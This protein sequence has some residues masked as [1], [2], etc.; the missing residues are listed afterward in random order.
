MS[1]P[2]SAWRALLWKDFQQVKSALLLMSFGILAFQLL[3]LFAWKLSP[4]T[5]FENP[6]YVQFAYC[7]VAPVLSIMACVGLLIGQERQ[8]GGWAWSSSLPQSWRQALASKACVAF[9]ASL[10]TLIPVA[11]SPVLLW[12]WRNPNHPLDSS[13]LT[14]IPAFVL[15]MMFELSVFLT[16]AV[17]IFRDSLTGLIVGGFWTAISQVTVSTVLFWKQSG[18]Q[19]D[20]TTWNYQE[21]GLFIF[22]EGI[23]L[24]LGTAAL[25][26]LFRWRWSYGQ[27]TDISLRRRRAIS[28]LLIYPQASRALS[29]RAAPR[30][31]FLMLVVHSLRSS[32]YLRLTIILSVIVCCWLCIR[33]RNFAARELIS[34]FIAVVGLALLGVTTFSDDHNTQ[35]YRFL[36]D[37]GVSTRR[38]V[39]A[40]LLPGI[41]ILALVIVIGAVCDY[42]GYV[43][44][45]NGLAVGITL[46]TALTSFY[47]VGAL[48]SLCFNRVIFS[49]VATFLTIFGVVNFVSFV[50]ESNFGH[51]D[52]NPG[53]YL[54]GVV[55]VAPL[56]ILLAVASI[57]WLA[58]K[59][60]IHD[61]VRLP[62]HFAWIMP[63]LTLS[64]F[65]MPMLFGFL[66]LPNVP[67][68]GVDDAQWKQETNKQLATEFMAFERWP[69]INR[70]SDMALSIESRMLDDRTN[71]AFDPTAAATLLRDSFEG[72]HLQWHDPQIQQQLTAWLDNIDFTL[73]APSSGPSEIET[74][75]MKDHSSRMS[76]QMQRE[77]AD[78]IRTSAILGVL[79]GVANHLDLSKR[80]WA[81]NKRLQ[82]LTETNLIS[83][84]KLSENRFSARA[85]QS[86]LT[87]L[88]SEQ[89]KQLGS[90]N[91]I[92][93]NL[94]PNASQSRSQMRLAMQTT[95]GQ[96]R[97]DLLRSSH[98]WDEL[99]LSPFSPVIKLVPT[100]RW[101]QERSLA[102]E[103]QKALEAIDADQ[104]VGPLELNLLKGEYDEWSALCLDR[105]LLDSRLNQIVSNRLE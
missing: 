66:F 59:L 99:I 55:C 25:L 36:A 58:R 1:N 2:T 63:S 21:V 16:V 100:L 44:L 4:Q 15:L 101:R 40:R 71:G 9:G 24:L 42:L 81:T 57:Y 82:E 65:M 33:S 38:F 52:I 96:L 47:I 54:I 91:E 85:F 27:S 62:R 75:A 86:L 34:F 51:T 17:L 48:C 19:P 88:S 60:M 79:L 93:N 53:W 39:T 41:V 102:L 3:T 87:Q 45:W 29:Q 30:S 97:N 11:I 43:Q 8:T 74:I 50:Q 72:P 46:L 73:S 31:E 28:T 67:W 12:Y 89:L 95:A 7:C 83:P 104:L 68:Q 80:M 23:L 22:Q 78:Q 10:L 26:W 98:N 6:I 105:A 14:W 77:R 32:L 37:R 69:Q 76:D 103:L 49:L 84:A 70:I 64:P 90:A 94:L 20:G 61:A 5:R 18:R 92:K 13:G 56:S 35:R